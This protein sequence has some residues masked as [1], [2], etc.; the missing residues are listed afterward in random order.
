MRFLLSAI[1]ALFT[2][3]LFSYE[4]G[5]YVKYHFKGY[6]SE[7]SELEQYYIKMEITEVDDDLNM[8]RLAQFNSN[9]DE[10]WTLVQERWIRGEILN[11]SVRF[12]DRYLDGCLSQQGGRV[13]SIPNVNGNPTKACR[14]QYQR[15]NIRPLLPS[16]FYGWA[17]IHYFG[18]FPILGLGK[19][20]TR[21]PTVFKM[22]LIDTN[23]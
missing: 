22:V 16:G 7:I 13:V 14:S 5:D 12:N 2:C 10:H 15:D 1:V 6:K 3:Q 18:N 17:E 20:E 11:P 21:K 4:K 9:M 19:L 23:L 8:V